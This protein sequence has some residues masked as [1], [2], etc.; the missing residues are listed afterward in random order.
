MRRFHI[1]PGQINNETA[2]IKGTEAH[3]IRVVLRMAAGEK[4]IL[5][6]GTGNEYD[7]RIQS[8]QPNSVFFHI[9]GTRTTTAEPQTQ[10]T[11]AQA[12]LKKKKMDGII[13]QLTEI[14]IAQFIPFISKRSI[15]NPSGNKMATTRNRWKTIAIEAVKQCRRSRPPKLWPITPFDDLMKTSDKGIILWENATE[16]LAGQLAEASI[17][18]LLNLTL[19]L[20]PEGGFSEAE[21]EKARRNGFITASLGPRILRAETAALAATVIAMNQLGEMS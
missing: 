6:D 2:H 15:P 17:N 4:V 11:V 9:T 16:P 3:H 18:G 7:A 19:V 8:I 1:L 13:R 20:G 5:F 10:V 14:G 21:I 12:L